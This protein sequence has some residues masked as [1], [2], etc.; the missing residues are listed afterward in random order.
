MTMSAEGRECVCR[1]QKVTPAACSDAPC[2]R[3]GERSGSSSDGGKGS[4]PKLSCEVPHTPVFVDIANVAYYE[5][6]AGEPHV[7]HE[8]CQ[9]K[10]VLFFASL[11]VVAL[12]VKSVHACVESV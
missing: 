4:P 7:R 5:S 10:R 12:R 3:D 1:V 2:E 11:I 8:T 6:R 9:R